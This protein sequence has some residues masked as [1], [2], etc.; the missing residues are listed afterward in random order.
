MVCRACRHAILGDEVVAYIHREV[1]ASPPPDAALI[2]ALRPILTNPA[3][4]DRGPR[5]TGPNGREC[6]APT[7]S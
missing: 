2:E 1:D 7:G 4:P 5:C 6:I 3:F